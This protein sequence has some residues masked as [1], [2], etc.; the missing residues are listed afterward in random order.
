MQDKI[1]EAF[2][3]HQF[4]E[5]TALARDSDLLELFP[6]G[7]PGAPPDRYVARFLCKGL[8]RD[9]QGEVAEANGFEV[10]VWFPSD[11]L[12]HVEPIQV[13][14]WLNP[15]GVFH[16]NIRPPFMCLGKLTPGTSLVDILYQCFEVI[17]YHNWAPHD[18]LNPEASQWAR[19]HQ[20]RLPVDKRPLKRRKLDLHC[21]PAQ[22]GQ[23]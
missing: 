13:V 4:Q 9:G 15:P 8:V 1:F 6:L 5:G 16:P 18:A 14:T 23:P 11:Y 22:G 20:D 19:N 3:R 17:T 21:T 7:T 12:R 10:G 2:L